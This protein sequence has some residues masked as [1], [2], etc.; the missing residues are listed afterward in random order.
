MIKVMMHT[1]PG[2]EGRWGG[3]GE[4]EGAIKCQSVCLRYIFLP[5]P[6]EE[7]QARRAG[8]SAAISAKECVKCSSIGRC[9]PCA[10]VRVAIS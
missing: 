4:R 8:V 6:K 3:W 7:V 5:P 9:C 10:S 1:A 2:N